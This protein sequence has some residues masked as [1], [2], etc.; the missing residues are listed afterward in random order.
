M[1][2]EKLM[3]TY[4]KPC[5][6]MIRSSKPCDTETI[7]S[8]CFDLDTGLETAEFEH[9]DKNLRRTEIWGRTCTNVLS[10]LQKLG[11]EP[12]IELSV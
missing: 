1:L 6:S 2:Q 3:K 11:K 8:R 9:T 4:T 5:N 7:F 10:G 12:S